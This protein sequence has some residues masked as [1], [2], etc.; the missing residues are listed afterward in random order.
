MLQKKMSKMLLKYIHRFNT[1]LVS[2]FHSGK[3]N[4]FSKLWLVRSVIQHL[5]F[6]N[7]F[8]DHYRQLLEG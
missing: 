3:P 6:R 2:I 8:E 5:L 4:K 7:R 1:K